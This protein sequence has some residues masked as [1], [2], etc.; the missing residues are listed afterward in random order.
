MTMLPFVIPNAVRN[1]DPENDFSPAKRQRDRNDRSGSG[2]QMT[3]AFG[4]EQAWKGLFY[5]T[6]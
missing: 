5:E 6:F 3:A 4:A 2:I 1:L